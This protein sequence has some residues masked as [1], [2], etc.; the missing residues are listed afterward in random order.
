MPIYLFSCCG[1]EVEVVQGIDKDSPLCPDCGTK[2]KRKLTTPAIITIKEEGGNR[3][4]SKGY[5]EGYAKDYRRRLQ[6]SK[7]QVKTVLKRL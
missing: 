7:T 5:K 1:K 3:T 4:Y 2:M 6:E